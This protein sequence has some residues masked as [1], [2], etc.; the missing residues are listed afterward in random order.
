MADPDFDPSIVERHVKRA[1]PAWTPSPELRDR[2][3]ARLA[4]SSAAT[5]G[6]VGLGAALQRPDP[7]PWATL[8]RAGK[9]QTLVGVG[10]VG[11]GFFSGYLVRA[12]HE[13]VSTKAPVA[14]IQPSS[15]SAPSA[16]A[17]VSDASPV[18]EPAG[19]TPQSEPSPPDAPASRER[20]R[21]GN[22]APSPAGH[23]QPSPTPDDGMSDELALLQRAERATRTGNAALAL[24]FIS[25]L[26]EEYPRSRFLEERRAIEL[27]ARCQADARD[28]AASADEFLRRQPKSL[29]AARVRQACHIEPAERLPERR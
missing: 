29:Y 2:V 23:P 27:L 11:A 7:G 9:L 10:L 17:G 12:L 19:A 20:R 14:T 28:A 8:L 4:S 26:T 13:P 5:L 15:S 24:A 16:P 22:V 1:W 18:E 25:E 3:R 6:A 21:A